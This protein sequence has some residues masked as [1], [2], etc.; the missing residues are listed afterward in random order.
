VD[1]ATAGEDVPNVA[2]HP[3]GDRS[4]AE[5]LASLTGLALGPETLWRLA[6]Q[7]GTALADADAQAA[8]TVARTQAAAEPLDA[9]PGLLVVETAG[10]LLRSTDGWHEVKLGLVAGWEDGRLQR[11]GYLAAR[12]SAEAFGGQLLAEAARWQGGVTGRGLAVLRAALILGDGA[13]WIWKLADDHWTQRL[14]GVDFYHASEHLA[15][16]AQALVADAADARAWTTARCQELLTAGPAPVLAALRQATAAT[17]PAREILR[18]DRGSFRQHAARMAYPTLRLDGL[19]IGSGAIEAAAAHVVQQRLQRP[20][21]RWS[22]AGAR[23]VLTRR[24]R[25]RSGRPL[26]A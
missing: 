4:A 1:A 17:P 24:A 21:L 12:A 7:V 2:A 14:E 22:T 9:A 3:R 13:A 6:R 20:G 8:A 23:A 18:R 16:V 25:D 19:P 26:V 15:T 5:R 11:P 10:V